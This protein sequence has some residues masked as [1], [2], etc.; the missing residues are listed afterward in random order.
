MIFVKN[1]K[2]DLI[3]DH[4]KGVK[5]TTKGFSIK[6]EKLHS[7]PNTA[8][9]SETDSQSAKLESEDGKSLRRNVMVKRDSD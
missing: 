8:Q 9:K 3:Q 6:E 7:T 5:T 1:N 4:H 2:A